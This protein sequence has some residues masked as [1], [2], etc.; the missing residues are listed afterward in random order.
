MK[1]KETQYQLSAKSFIEGQYEAYNG[2]AIN[3]YTEEFSKKYDN[4][5]QECSPL[6]G[7]IVG[8]D[9]YN[10]LKIQHGIVGLR[11]KINEFNKDSLLVFLK[12]H[13]RADSINEVLEKIF[14]DFLSKYK[15][16]QNEAQLYELIFLSNSESPAN[17][18]REIFLS[19]I[20]ESFSY[21]VI[22]YEKPG[23]YIG[24]NNFYT[25]RE[26]RIPVF[27][28]QRAK[29]ERPDFLHYI[30]GIP[31]ILI[32]YKTENSGI[33]DSLKDFEFKESYKKAPFKVALNDGRDVL[34][35]SD[36]NCL[37]FKT[38]KDNSFMW[39]HY[40]N[41]KKYIGQ[42]EFTNTEYLLDEL[43]C[44][45]ENLYSYCTDGCS[46]INHKGQHYLINARIQQYYAIKDIRRTLIEAQSSRLTLPYNFEFAH[47]QR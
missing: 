13:K 35:F 11:E 36:I 41:D 44:Q 10:E 6:I 38:A 42:R 8:N 17:T 19:G 37:K 24:K 40:L 9:L 47:A 43:L 2:R 30:N 21:N 23:K 29:E 39:V 32:E 14:Q 26:R 27:Y 25:I 12:K 34:F 4:V 45:P 22:Y 28:A 3:I 7:G 33:I 1:N 16:A 15:A 31:L 46:L 20:R 18:K 5:L